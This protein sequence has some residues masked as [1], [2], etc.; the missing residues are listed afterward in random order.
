MVAVEA[1]VA[2]QQHRFAGAGRA[3]SVLGWILFFVPF[4]VYFWL[5]ARY[6]TNVPRL[7]DFNAVLGFLERW[8]STPDLAARLPLLFEQHYEHRIFTVRLV[9][10]ADLWLFGKTN[11]HRLALYGAAAWMGAVGVLA[12]LL[13]KRFELSIWKL[14][15]IPYLLLTPAHHELM[16]WASASIQNY[17]VFLFVFPFLACLAGGRV[18]RLEV[19]APTA[20]FTSGAGIA[21]LPLGIAEL[22]R[23]R[24]WRGAALFGATAGALVAVY[25]AGYVTPADHF[26]LWVTLGNPVRMLRFLLAFMGSCV[27]SPHDYNS[28][29]EAIGLITITALVFCVVRY[30][31]ERFLCLLVGFVL[32]TAVVAALKRSAWGLGFGAASRYTMYHQLAWA[33]VYG[34]GLYATTGR[35]SRRYIVVAAIILSSLV[36]G[37]TVR[38]SLGPMRLQS[39][40]QLCWIADSLWGTGTQPNYYIDPAVAAKHLQNSRRLNIYDYTAAIGLRDP[41][42]IDRHRLQNTQMPPGR[43]RVETFELNEL[44][45]TL[46]ATETLGSEVSLV[47]DGSAGLFAL[48]FRQFTDPDA[49]SNFKHEFRPGESVCRVCTAEYSL[50]GGDYAVGLLNEYGGDRNFVSIPGVTL[51]VRPDEDKKFTL[52]QD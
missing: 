43:L 22:L 3:A 7:D 45:A 5:A 44:T 10:L 8:R 14:L 23:Q 51:Q 36:F 12:Y 4:A 33:T 46:I 38:R 34:F 19:Y 31:P 41:Q 17:G 9:C 13:R 32:L 25:F 28:A 27:G 18:G 20:L 6:A 1:D 35:A 16:T 48:P 47:L 24:R 49:L 26:P 42:R 30:W 11:F 52:K 39:F 37:L 50:P 21:L 15:P 29:V 2:A 40:R